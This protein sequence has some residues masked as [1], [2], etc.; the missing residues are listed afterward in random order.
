LFNFLKTQILWLYIIFL[1]LITALIFLTIFPEVKLP[2]TIYFLVDD[3]LIPNL[4]WLF[5]QLS[6]YYSFLLLWLV[7]ITP[8][9]PD[10]F[11]W[12]DFI[13]PL[14]FQKQVTYFICYTI[15]NL[16]ELWNYFYQSH[17]LICSL[18]EALLLVYVSIKVLLNWLLI[19]VWPF[20]LAI[21]YHYNNFFFASNPINS[22]IKT[23]N[24][25]FFEWLLLYNLF[26]QKQDITLL[27]NVKL[28]R[29]SFSPQDWFSLWLG[30]SLRVK[31]VDIRRCSNLN[32][33]VI[34]F[35]QN[36]QL[37]LLRFLIFISCKNNLN[38]FQISKQK[39]TSQ[40]LLLISIAD[41]VL[42]ELKIHPRDLQ[43]LENDKF[44]YFTI[45]NMLFCY[46]LKFKF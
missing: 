29:Y 4:I 23:E 40:S 15:P 24:K 14:K 26:K 21:F 9:F 32:F 17:E 2:K 16:A 5:I 45:K 13:F 25:L 10:V 31:W 35:F 34:L 7:E 27:E 3:F 33:P 22:Y 43:E 12:I 44:L 28:D 46:L 39:T 19:Y 37:M 1:A 42:K 30:W 20:L 38:L 36:N 41:N 6:E 8:P 18:V 11:G